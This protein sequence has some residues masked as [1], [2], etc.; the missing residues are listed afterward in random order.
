[1]V[2]KKRYGVFSVRQSWK[3]YTE[4][5]EAITYS[6]R[7]L[8][9]SAGEQ[10]ARDAMARGCDV[11]LHIQEASGELRQADMIALAH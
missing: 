1:M 4:G 7:A 8:A 6:D 2:R 11:E 5:G 9:V 10:A 3:L